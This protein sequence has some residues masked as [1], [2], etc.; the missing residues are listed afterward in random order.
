M[1]TRNL[2]F[3]ILT[4]LWMGVIFSQS[5]KVADDSAAQSGRLLIHI[6]EHFITGF[7]NWPEEK[8]QEFV[9]KYDH[10]VR[11][12]AHMTEYAVLCMLLVGTMYK[13]GK[14]DGQEHENRRIFAIYWLISTVY[15]A[16]DE[17]HQTFV[18]GRS[19][20]VKDVCFDSAGALIGV[21]LAIIIINVI[22]SMFKD[23][24]ER[25]YSSLRL[26]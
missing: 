21:F 14:K 4:I 6:G 12:G 19:G 3:L 26:K 11:K 18:P 16:T 22:K 17:F 13:A 25:T 20:E 7:E 2:I 23:K 15:A 10:P 1:K 9:E 24:S 8:K 5:A